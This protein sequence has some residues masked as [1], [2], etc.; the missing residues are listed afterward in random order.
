MDEALILDRRPH[1]YPHDERAAGFFARYDVSC[2][3]RY[4]KNLNQARRK[5]LATTQ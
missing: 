5:P 1:V 4:V 2:T 3:Q